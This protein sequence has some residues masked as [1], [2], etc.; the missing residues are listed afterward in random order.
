MKQEFMTSRSEGTNY[1]K[2]ENKDKQSF[3]P[4]QQGLNRLS[5]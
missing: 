1:K 5:V 3:P 2:R 4:S